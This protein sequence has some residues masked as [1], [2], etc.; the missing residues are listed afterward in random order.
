MSNCSPTM[1]KLLEW[2][3]PYLAE[4]VYRYM[5]CDL[6]DGEVR[7]KRGAAAVRAAAL[8]VREFGEPD[9]KSGKVLTERWV[10]LVHIGA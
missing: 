2:D 4:A 9:P 3:G 7:F 10:N 5:M 6:E 8:K 1:W